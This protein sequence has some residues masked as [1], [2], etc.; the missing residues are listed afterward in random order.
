MG[1]II[2]LELLTIP[3]LSGKSHRGHSY[4]SRGQDVQ[5]AGTMKINSQGII[6]NITNESGH[7]RPNAAETSNFPKILKQNGFNVDNAWIRING[8]NVDGAN[9]ITDSWVIYNG[10]VKYMPDI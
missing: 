5:A 10:P 4:L 1:G 7:Y 8:F 6:R 9:Y 3:F 2:H